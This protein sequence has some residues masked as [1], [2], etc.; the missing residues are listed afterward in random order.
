MQI[1][2]GLFVVKECAMGILYTLVQRSQQCQGAR[3]FIHTIW[4]TI[5][6]ALAV[7]NNPSM[8]PPNTDR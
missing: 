5:T 7:K 1:S 3:Y 6:P 8:F 2:I 4:L